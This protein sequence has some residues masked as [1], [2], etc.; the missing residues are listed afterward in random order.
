MGILPFIYFCFSSSFICSAKSRPPLLADRTSED[1]PLETWFDSFDLAPTFLSAGARGRISG[2]TA[3]MRSSRDRWEMVAHDY[4]MMN[5]TGWSRSLLVDDARN[6][7][8]TAD[9]WSTRL[10]PEKS[11]SLVRSYAP[12]CI[13]GCAQARIVLPSTEKSRRH[14]HRGS[15]IAQKVGARANH[16]F[17]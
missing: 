2:E 15:L 1:A 13:T 5:W 17:I 11:N 3:M 12:A 16:D 10:K 8:D 6:D 4:D 7:V 9:I 14:V